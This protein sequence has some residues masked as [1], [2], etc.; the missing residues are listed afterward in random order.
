VQ[1]ALDYR[2]E[3]GRVEQDLVML[4]DSISGALAH[5]LWIVN[6][7]ALRAQIG[8]MLRLPHL[9]YVEVTESDGTVYRAG[10][11]VPLARDRVERVFKLDYVHPHTGRA[12]LVGSVRLEAS[13]A[14]IKRRL[15]DRFLV[16]LAT[17]G[18]KTFVVALFIL[19]FF[20]WLVTR[21]LLRLA[22]QV[23]AITSLTL[24]EPL[25]LA[26]QPVNDE[27][28]VLLQ[29]LNQM[30]HGLLRDIEL[31]ESSGRALAAEQVA[32]QRQLQSLPEAVFTLDARGAVTALN[33]AAE[34]LCGKPS[35]RAAGEALGAVL[36]AA[37]GFATWS[38]ERLFLE[39]QGSSVPLRR[40]VVFVHDD[41]RTLGCAASAA[42]VGEGDL[43][44]RQV[45]LV[46]MAPEVL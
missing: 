43:P 28:Q 14:D 39:A 1:L 19:M 13:T 20:Q 3:V 7:Q 5:A 24:R 26:R 6:P 41:G 36:P 42:Q 32:A 31:W 46:L 30:R 2:H 11:P 21:H 45:V 12:E 10:R 33:P 22:E 37:A 40:R 16:I 23:R 44:S 35:Y 4:Q 18:L 8:D 15:F 25:T 38:A 34:R 17:Q 29:A 27:L 9:R